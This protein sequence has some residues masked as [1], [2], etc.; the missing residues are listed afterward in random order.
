[1]KVVFTA[2]AE[3]QIDQLHSFIT[4]NANEKRADAYVS[5]TIEYCEGLSLFPGRG[6]ARDDIVPGLRVIGFERRVMIAFLVTDDAVL[7]EGVFS[8]G[9]D[10]EGALFDQ[11]PAD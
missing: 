6:R 4:I 10:F 11:N 2:F 3:S 8:G 5:R 1:M 7:I 9:Q